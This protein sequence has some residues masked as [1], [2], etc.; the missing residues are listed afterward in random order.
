MQACGFPEDA[1]HWLSCRSW[2]LFGTGIAKARGHVW[3]V[4]SARVC[5]ASETASRREQRVLAGM[6]IKCNLCAPVRS[7]KHGQSKTRIDTDNTDLH[8][9][10]L[11][12][13]I[14]RFLILVH[15]EQSRQQSSWCEKRQTCY[16]L[17][18]AHH[19]SCM[20]MYIYAHKC[21]DP[22]QQWAI[23]KRDPS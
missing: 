11:S 23:R 7:L 4:L 9:R 16:K 1:P 14:A 20:H 10:Q 18:C 17:A 5:P 15:L 21:A 6:A 22:P 12:S 13:R 8:A 3:S 2:C 19:S